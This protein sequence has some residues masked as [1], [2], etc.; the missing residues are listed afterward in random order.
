MKLKILP[1]SL[2]TVVALTILE[3]HGLSSAQEDQP[4]QVG[5]LRMEIMI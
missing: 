1:V 5:S 2:L 4:H 3:D